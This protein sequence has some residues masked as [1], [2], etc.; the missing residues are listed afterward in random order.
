MLDLFYF[1]FLIFLLGYFLLSA[2]KEVPLVICSYALCQYLMTQFLWM[3]QM[4]ARMSG[5]LLLFICLTVG[6]LIW[7]RSLPVGRELNTLRIFFRVSG[8]AIVVISLIIVWKKGP[9]LLELSTGTALPPSSGGW[10]FL[11][12]LKLSGNALLF[13]FFILFILNWGERLSIRQSLWDYAPFLLFL[14]VI[15]MLAAM[16]PSA[17]GL[18]V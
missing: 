14:T 4:S 18:I 11:P 15:A 2:R 9:F 3:N 6:V 10:R 12:A 5:L 1:L 16:L 17:G 8:W 13:T 7:G